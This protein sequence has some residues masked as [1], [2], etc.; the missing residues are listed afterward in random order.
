V[1]PVAP[2]LPS[3]ILF[4]RAP[5]PGNVKTRLAPAL[6]EAGAARLYRAFLED[7]ARAYTGRGD[8]SPVVCADSD[9]AREDLAAIFGDAWRIESQREGDLGGRLAEAFRRE[10]D[11][12]APRALAVGS[13][14]PALSRRRLIEA[15]GF[16]GGGE[17]AAIIPAQDGGYCAIG[18]TAGAPVEAVFRDVPWSTDRVLDVT[19]VR[20][21]EAGVTFRLLEPAYDVDRP[22]DLSRLV[23]DLATRPRDAD[24]PI[25]TAEALETLDL[26]AS[27]VARGPR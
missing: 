7:A 25:A 9:R 15:F 13:D 8:W 14:H 3:L 2:A 26:L 18:L 1:P 22:E 5:R 11:G 16:L 19:L 27:P 17:Q 6:G 23:R 10:F 21:R 24:Y 20:L 4:A 12:G